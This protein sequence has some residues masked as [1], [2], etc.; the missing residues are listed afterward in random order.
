MAM[1]EAQR[2]EFE[3]SSEGQRIRQAMAADQAARGG[4]LLEQHMAKKQHRKEAN[5]RGGVRE[6]FDRE[7]DVVQAGQGGD[8]GAAKLLIQQ[9]R[10]LHGKFTS[11]I[12]KHF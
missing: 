3:R 10:E 1:K 9:A 8:S 2:D 11:T 6:R 5:K 12:Q 7:R 4:S